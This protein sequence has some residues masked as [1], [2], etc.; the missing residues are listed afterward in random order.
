MEHPNPETPHRRSEDRRGRIVVL[1]VDDQRFVAV[2]VGRLLA[3]EPDIDFHWC[4]NVVEAVARANELRPTIILQDLIL[5][6]IDGLTMV[7]LFRANPA[8]ASAAIVVLSGD[9]SAEA[10]ASASAA[11]AADESVGTVAR[12]CQGPETLDSRVMADYRQAGPA[13]GPD[14]AGM[15]IDGF[16]VEA[17]SQ[18]EA[19]RTA[20]QRQDAA[21]LKAT[22]H[23]LKGTSMTI[24]ANKLASLCAQV[25]DHV[26]NHPGDSIAVGLMADIDR[27]FGK[28]QEA[29]AMERQHGA[30]P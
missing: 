10:R 1:L 22:A 20:R 5:P 25:E 26:L 12:D 24:G 23:T 9:D 13:G 30:H 16:I 15:L 8:V 28:V 18:V 19:L 6:D 27:E 14:F 3:S 21:T 11:G 17:T 4:Q 29:L 7:R 2:A